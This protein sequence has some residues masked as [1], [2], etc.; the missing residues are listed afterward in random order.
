MVARADAR[1]TEEQ[2]WTTLRPCA[3]RHKR[4]QKITGLDD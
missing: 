4:F 3:Q 1:I 2:G